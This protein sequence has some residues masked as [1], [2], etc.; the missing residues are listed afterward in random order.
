MVNGTSP[1]NVVSI[2]IVTTAFLTQH[3][4]FCF[5]KKAEFELIFKVGL[6]GWVMD[7]LLIQN[8]IIRFEGS[9]AGGGSLVQP[10]WMSCLWLSLGA[11]LN[12]SLAWLKRFRIWSGLIGAVVGTV[13]YLSGDKLGVLHFESPLSTLVTAFYW[14]LTLPILVF[15]SSES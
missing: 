2:L 9:Y 14:G 6:I 12:Y 10:F 15:L 3:I 13:S 1:F 11:S 5:D 8:N 4:Y 7:T